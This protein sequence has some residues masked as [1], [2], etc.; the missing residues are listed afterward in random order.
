MNGQDRVRIIEVLLHQI[1]HAR[2]AM[3]M[4]KDGKLETWEMVGGKRVNTT[5][6]S[7]AIHSRAAMDMEAV[8]AALEEERDPFR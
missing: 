2:R 8:Y 7:L 1:A 6:D 5:A 4:M 3:E